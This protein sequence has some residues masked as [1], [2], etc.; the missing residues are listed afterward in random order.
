MTEEGLM[1]IT[2]LLFAALKER[3]ETGQLV[4][5]IDDGATV[6]D[7][8]AKISIEVGFD[9]NRESFMTAVNQHYGLRTT[10]LSD[11]D[12]LALIPPVSG[13]GGINETKDD[14]MV[15]LGQSPPVVNHLVDFVRGDSYGANVV[16]HGTTRNH[17]L[18]RRVIKLYYEAYE[19]M[20]AKTVRFIV[21][22]ARS[23]LSFGR[24]AVAHRL[25]EV[26]IGET[27][28]VVAVSAE[29]RVEAFKAIQTIIDDIKRIVPI[30]KKEHF[31][32]GVEWIG[33]GAPEG[34]DK[35]T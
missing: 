19:T 5:Q 21:A 1:K 28:M 26:P 9:L 3:A 8:L 7:A 34:I 30:W 15:I 23:Q 20:V 35:E 31:E 22:Q 25:G 33:A 12:E 10:P 16:F 27:S 6:L 32:G 14:V 11:G 18:N 13:G 17:N 4:L 24:V 2:V 29:H